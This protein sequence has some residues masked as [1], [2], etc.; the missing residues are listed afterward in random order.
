[1]R[2]NY[3]VEV[4]KNISLSI[5]KEMQT[6]KQSKVRQL[7][8]FLWATLYMY[9]KDVVIWYSG[10]VPLIIVAHKGCIS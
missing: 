10:G 7:S 3:R 4:E 5:R 2:I 6:I 1:M 8:F 9:K